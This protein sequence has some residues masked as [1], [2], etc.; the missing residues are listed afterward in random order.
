MTLKKVLLF[1]VE[2]ALAVAFY[3]A[4]DKVP[5]SRLFN[6]IKHGAAVSLEGRVNSRQSD[7]Q[8]D[9]TSRSGQDAGVAPP[10]ADLPQSA[11]RTGVPKSLNECVE[12]RIESIGSRLEGVPESGSAI[13][14]ENGGYQVGYDTLT[15]IQESRPGDSVRMC[16]VSFESDCPADREPSH[17]YRVTNSRTAKS[18]TRSDKSHGCQGA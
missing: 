15:E 2:C 4:F 3:A 18:W 1:I 9:A 17:D 13:W 14:F 7:R 16:L 12:T 11:S 10:G 8:T 6:L 5:W